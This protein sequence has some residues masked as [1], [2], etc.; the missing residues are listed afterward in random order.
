[1]P[2]AR[3]AA[4]FLVA[5]WL[6][7]AGCGSE[8]GSATNERDA[9][10]GGSSANDSGMA[11]ESSADVA[12]DASTEDV[13]DGATADAPAAC[14]TISVSAATYAANC[15]APTEVASVGAQCNGKEACTYT[16][17]YTVDPGFDP[18]QGC[19][20][21]MTVSYDCVDA[22]NVV[23]E[24]KS[25]YAPPEAGSAGVLDLACGCT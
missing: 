21:D 14:P 5:S 13:S 16:M 2:A 15:S 9:G 17:D 18:A 10:S 25:A 1:M 8:G 22:A 4:F 20:K 11:G 24:S 23:V 12:S 6:V 19:A 7:A 3:L